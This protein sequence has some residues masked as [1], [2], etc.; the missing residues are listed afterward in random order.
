MK[1][2]RKIMSVIALCIV[3]V[4]TLTACGGGKAAT[5]DTEQGSSNSVEKAMKAINVGLMNAPSGFN[6]L[7]STDVSQ[8]TC[9]AILFNPLVELDIDMKYKL[10]LADSI[11]TEDNQTF[12]VK[13]NEK[14]KWTDGEPITADDVVFTVG[15]ISN[16]KVPS[17]I[18]SKFALLEGLDDNGKNTSGSD[19]IAGVK[20]VDDHTIEFKTK[21][22]I[23]IILFKDNIG[24]RLKT[25]PKHI[26]EDAELESLYQ[27]PHILNPDVTSGAFKLVKYAK[28]Q[29]VQFEANKDYFK[30]TPKIDQLNF[31][32]MQ[33]SNI[34]VQLESGEIDM[35][36]PNI[37]LIPFE[38]YEKVKNMP[39]VN[40]KT[41]G[42][43]G[44]IQ[45]LMINNEKI[46]DVKVREALSYALNRKM[47]AESLL[48]GDGAGLELPY[49][50]NS[51]YLNKDIQMKSYD[52][53]KAEELLKE[54]SWDP[55]RTLNF[56]V[57]TG[58]KV[59]EKV[60][61]IIVDNLTDVG[62]KVRVQKY[63]FVTSLAKARNGE[64]DIYI[65]GIPVYPTNPDISTILQSGGNLNISRYSNPEMD[66]LLQAGINEVDTEKRQEIYNKVQELFMK[67]LPCPSIYVQNALKAVNKRITYGEPKDYG[68]F[69][70]VYKW[71]VE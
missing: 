15:L 2:K 45:T 48:K 40:T 61:D 1:M 35:N 66:E 52:P 3:I 25:V 51:Q 42:V 64:F 39:N 69:I 41:E 6:P 70:D 27:N 26:F 28:D 60:A 5:T 43:P 62:I 30:G 11:E 65:V 68:M 53:E 18:A 32:I 44:A 10:M 9:S 55:D 36:E 57:P 50:N 7:E 24:T 46:T 8:N 20:K 38:D 21:K 34:T 12:T 54:A 67:D 71:D 47:I 16:P 63:D 31:K 59:R 22:A 14:A 58:N 13:L 33:G 17:T 19:S 4:L 29:Y 23:D 56:D 37:G 49:L